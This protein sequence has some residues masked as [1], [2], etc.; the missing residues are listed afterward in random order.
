M[1]KIENEKILAE[2]SLHGA[3]LSRLYN[4]EA[5]LEALWNADGKYWARHAPVLFPNVG[6]YYKGSLTH[7]GQDFPE[8]QHGFARDCDFVCTMQERDKAAF[9]LESTGETLSRYP[10]PFSLEIAYELQ[11]SAVKVTWKVINTGNGTMYFTIGGHPA[12]NVPAL[13]GTAFTDY[14]LYFEGKDSLEYKLLDKASGCVI[15][16]S[17]EVLPLENG[18]YRLQEDMFDNDALVFD[19][20][21][22]DRVAILYPDKRPYI[23]MECAGFP[24][25][26]IWS[27]HGAPFVCLEPWVG[28]TDNAG[29]SGEISTKPGVT[30]LNVGE[31]FEKSHRI[32]VG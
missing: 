27:K 2:I 19:G 26:G 16:D 28:R 24:N 14:F 5:G 31:V 30:A 4:K 12:F 21:Q 7:K 3:E 25:F 22:I 1:I 10:F 9:V 20:G 11:G 32:I 15:A 6:K 18:M 29:F 8:G 23:T 13:E 17:G